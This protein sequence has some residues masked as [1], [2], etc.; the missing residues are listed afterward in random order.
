VKRV[1]GQQLTKDPQVLGQQ[2]QLSVATFCKLPRGWRPTGPPAKRPTTVRKRAAVF[3][4]YYAARLERRP[5][6]T[7]SLP[8][9]GSNPE[10]SDCE[11]GV[12]TSRSR[13]RQKRVFLMCELTCRQAAAWNPVGT[14][15]LFAMSGDPRIYSLTFADSRLLDAPVVDGGSLASVAIDLTPSEVAEQT[16]KRWFDWNVVRCAGCVWPSNSVLFFKI[17]FSDPADNPFVAIQP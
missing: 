2:D 11:S 9:R 3:G 14:V 16:M 10:L 1:P 17:T 15:L 4:P 8:G 12:V 5:Q 7:L 13:W 6:T